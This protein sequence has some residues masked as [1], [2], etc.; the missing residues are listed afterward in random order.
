MNLTVITVTVPH[1]ERPVA[2]IVALPTTIWAKFVQNMW[3]AKANGGLAIV[4]YGPNNVTATVADGKT[5]KFRQ[6]TD[7][8]FRDTVQLDYYGDTAAFDLDLR[9]PEWA[10]SATVTVNGAGGRTD[11]LLLHRKQNLGS[12]RSGAGNLWQRSGTDHLV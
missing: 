6:K 9:I 4:A 7:Y 10:T 8:P 3:M 1:S 12:R 5:A 2:L 11:W